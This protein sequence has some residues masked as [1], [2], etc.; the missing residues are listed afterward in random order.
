MTTKPYRDPLHVPYKDLQIKYGKYNMILNKRFID[1]QVCW[2]NLNLIKSLF[3]IK[4]SIYTRMNRSSKLDTIR[5]QA[6]EA[7]EIEFQIQEAFN[8][9]RNAAFHRFWEM[10]KCECPVMD[11]Q[12]YWGSDQSIHT[13]NCPIHGSG[14]D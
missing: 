5:A 3:K 10:P 8:F 7:T 12:D 9:P 6:A 4:F 14:N 11:N 1:Q 13:S 2:T